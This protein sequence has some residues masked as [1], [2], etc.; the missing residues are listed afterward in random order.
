LPLNPV[1]K[2]QSEAI[3]FRPNSDFIFWT[4]C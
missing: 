1:Q 3:K 4:I 2:L